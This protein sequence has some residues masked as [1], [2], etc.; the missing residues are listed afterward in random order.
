MVVPRLAELSSQNVHQPTKADLSAC[1]TCTSTRE[2]SAT[3]CGSASRRRSPLSSRRRR[4]STFWTA[5]PGAKCELLRPA[6][7]TS[8]VPPLCS[9]RSQASAGCRWGRCTQRE[10]AGTCV[11]NTALTDTSTWHGTSRYA[12]QPQPLTALHCQFSARQLWTCNLGPAHRRF[13]SFLAN[14]YAAAKRFGLEGC[15]TLIPGMKAMI[16]HAADLGVETV[17]VGMPHRGGDTHFQA[18]CVPARAAGQ[19]ANGWYVF[20]RAGIRHKSSSCYQPQANLPLVEEA[21]LT[22]ISWRRLLTFAAD[23][24]AQGA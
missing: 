19:S 9:L 4:R 13:E 23:A 15:E 22:D 2:S 6:W 20:W 1:S 14:K 18:C 24:P 12:G 11:Q 3:G 8:S 17:C 10:L 16:D 21:G 5:S 7:T